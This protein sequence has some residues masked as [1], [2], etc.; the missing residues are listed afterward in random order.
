MNERGS[1]TGRFDFRRGALRGSSLTLYPTGL[2]YR[3]AAQFDIM[4]LSGIGAVRVAYERDSRRVA[5]GVTLVLVA[6]AVFAVSGLLADLAGDAANDMAS[7]MRGDYPV[8]AQG[9]VATLHAAFLFLQ[10]LAEAFPIAAGALGLWA[11]ALIGFGALGSTTLT[12]AVG[13][14][15]RAYA[16]PG[17]NTK[18][19]DFAEMVGEA[20]SQVR[21]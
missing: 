16:V 7:R 6:L 10:A 15:E 11:L 13:S 8:A 20:L 3:G 2:V 21:R 14:S 18:L 5:W 19:F 9:I 12:V 17:R 4:A 1:A